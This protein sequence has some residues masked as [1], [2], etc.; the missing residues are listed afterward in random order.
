MDLF[1]QAE[2]TYKNNFSPITCFERALFFSW[3]CSI[4][5]CTFCFMSAQPKDVE[6]KTMRRSTESLLAEAI[7]C[8]VLG[9][10]SGFL[11]GGIN[12]FS[13]ED[14]KRLLPFLVA[15]Y[16]NKFWLNIGPL[17]PGLLEAY[18]PHI[19]GVVGAIETVNPVM[20]KKICP[21]KPM[22]PYLRM[23]ATAHD[24]GL[25]TAMTFIVGVGETKEDLPLL[26]EIIERYHISK[27]HVYSLVPEKGTTY[28]EKD[29]P[30]PES[31]AWWIAQV[32]IHFPTINIQCGI[33]KD[34][35]ASLPLLLR[36]GANSFSKFPATRLFGTKY[37]YDIEEQ[38]RKAG[39]VFQGTLTQLPDVDWT[40]EIRM[41]PVDD[42]LKERVRKKIAQYIQKMGKNLDMNPPL[43]QKTH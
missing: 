35:I 8:R 31:Q 5:D 37:A 36:A 9:W 30:S 25:H 41:L 22:E 18:K 1:T 40:R 34:R 16:G 39:R 28:T 43:L 6:P 4:R 24:M 23:F 11:S 27:I 17:S 15:A 12:A 20:H 10:D 3:Y 29:I 21:S 19:A 42:L 38:V 13:P 7:L 32:R 14:M 33:W 2:E 26:L